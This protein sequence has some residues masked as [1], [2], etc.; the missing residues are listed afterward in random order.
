MIMI[1]NTEKLVPN[2]LEDN[3]NE[4]CLA[5]TICPNCSLEFGIIQDYI[6]VITC[7]YCGEYVEG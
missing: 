7:P 2:Q 3:P 4:I 6:G 1:E 5:R